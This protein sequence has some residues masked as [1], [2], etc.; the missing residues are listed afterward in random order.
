[1]EHLEFFFGSCVKLPD[2][3]IFHGF[4]AAWRS[5][6]ISPD[7]P[8]CWG[9]NGQ[10]W[11]Q[12]SWL[13][14]SGGRFGSSHQKGSWVRE[15]SFFQGNLGWWNHYNWAQNIRLYIPYVAGL[16]LIIIE[17]AYFSYLY[18]C[19]SCR[20]LWVCMMYVYWIF[21]FHSSLRSILSLR[22]P[23][24]GD[25]KNVLRRHLVMLLEYNLENSR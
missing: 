21:I 10:H 1:M 3:L 15:I 11:S 6:E 12:Q 24:L 2:F 8:E 9:G 19:I 20:Y 23:F 14:I 5:N 16:F 25:L 18:M 7:A 22:S 17:Q 13:C 4:L